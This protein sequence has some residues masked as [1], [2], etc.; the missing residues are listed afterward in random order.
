MILRT[1]IPNQNSNT[2][3][4]MIIA[5][6]GTRQEMA[7]IVSFMQTLQTLHLAE[8]DEWSPIITTSNGAL[9]AI[10]SRSMQ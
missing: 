9:I 8:I 10:L 7:A 6:I 5:I 4:R 1:L 2:N 3:R